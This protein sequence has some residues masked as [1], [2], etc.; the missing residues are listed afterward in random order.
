MTKKAWTPPGKVQPEEP[1]MTPEERCETT[2]GQI[3]KSILEILQDI[4]KTAEAF[5][6]LSA[7]SAEEYKRTTFQ[8]AKAEEDFMQQLLRCDNCEVP[9]DE[10]RQKRRE[11]IKTIQGH[12]QQLDQTKNKVNQHSA[13]TT[14][15]KQTEDSSGEDIEEAV[16][17][18]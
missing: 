2:L 14:E 8:L 1:P 15:T 5:Y 11:L 3:E 9:D 13:S 17:L 18:D 7:P 12:Q 10:W 16:G 4:E 6:G